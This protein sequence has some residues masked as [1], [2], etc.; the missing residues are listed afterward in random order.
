MRRRIARDRLDGPAL[1]VPAAKQPT[2][3]WRYDTRAA[4]P[5]FEPCGARWFFLMRAAFTDELPA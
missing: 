2:D 1:I 5:P 4:I 3:I